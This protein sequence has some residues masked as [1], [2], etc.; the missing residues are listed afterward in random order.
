MNKHD[1]EESTGRGS[2]WDCVERD[3][4]KGPVLCRWYDIFMFK[5][6]RSPPSMLASV[7]CRCRCADT[8][9]LPIIAFS[10]P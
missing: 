6:A 1:G 9:S 4:K 7:M 2:V 8:V 5:L 10:Y 3:K